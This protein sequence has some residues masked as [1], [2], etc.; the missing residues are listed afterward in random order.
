MLA[1]SFLLADTQLG[2]GAK[3]AGELIKI[4]PDIPIIVCS[5]YSDAINEKMAKAAGIKAFIMKPVIRQ[6][7]A[8][9]IREIFDGEHD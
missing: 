6:K 2:A 9:T 4:R 3:L 1:L 5:G 8:W 7:L